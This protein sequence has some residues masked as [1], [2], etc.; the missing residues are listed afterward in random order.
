LKS[1]YPDLIFLAEAFTR[2]RVMYRLAKLGFNQSYTYF[3]WRN[4]KT[5][6]TEYLIELTS[7]PAKYVFRPNFWPNTP[8]ILPEY[9]QFDSRQAFITRLVL[10]ATLSSNYGIYGPAYELMQNR[11]LPGREEYEASEKYEIKHWDWRAPNSLIEL[12]SIVNSIR[13]ENKALQQTNNLRFLEIENEYLLA[14]MKWNNDH[15]NTVVVIVNLDP[16]HKHGGYLSLPLE[17]IGVELNQSYLIRD[18]L[19]EEKYLWQSSRNYVEL[20]PY[21]IPAHVFRIHKRIKR[22][23]DFDYFI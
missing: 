1:R 5:E 3:T 22:E 10:A 13:L 20:D 12:I 6:L 15:S 11:A 21:V 9:L 18:L 17:E 23:Q 7:A 8:D 19:S 16:F 2:P 14:Y 4:T